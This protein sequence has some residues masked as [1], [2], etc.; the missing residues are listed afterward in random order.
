MNVSQL[1]RGY[2][3]VV[4]HSGQ[5]QEVAIS[6]SSPVRSAARV[7]P[8]EPQTLKI[9]GSGWKMEL[10]AFAGAVVEWKRWA[11]STC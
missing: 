11:P 9:E 2:A 10:A 8:E 1:P 3:V 7:S 5:T 6:A 4:N